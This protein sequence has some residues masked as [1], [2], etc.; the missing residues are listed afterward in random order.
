MWKVSESGDDSI[1]ASA[2]IEREE[3]VQTRREDCRRPIESQETR[4]AVDPNT[5]VLLSAA[6]SWTCDDSSN[7]T[8]Q[9]T[10]APVC[11]Y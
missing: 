4:W 6:S 7:C 11:V 5:V 1:F 3:V 9:A 10:P 8:T 2:R